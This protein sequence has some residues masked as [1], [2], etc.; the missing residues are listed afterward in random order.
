MDIFIIDKN[1]IILP[2]RK[3][4]E[5]FQ[6]KKFSDSEK[7][8]EHCLSYYIL[9]KILKDN[10]KIEKRELE[11]ISRKPHLKSREIHFSISHSHNFIVI[12][13]SR[14]NCGIDIEFI[15][16]RNFFKLA[17]RMNFEGC[18]SLKDFY[19]KWTEYEAIYK[20]NDKYEKIEHYNYENYIISAV[21]TN[22]NE[23][24]QFIIKN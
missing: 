16:E 2:D 14:Y 3:I 8:K 24:F 21:S 13:I 22:S 7:F 15:K 1:K 11:F 6:Y 20:L 4:L 10:Y 5:K 23:I 19:N 17:K 12:A 9:D 18:C